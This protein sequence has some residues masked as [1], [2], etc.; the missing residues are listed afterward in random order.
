[1]ALLK[2]GSKEYVVD[3]AFI[4]IYIYIYRFII[5]IRYQYFPLAENLISLIDRHITVAVCSLLK[6]SENSFMHS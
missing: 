2:R 3:E 1:M 4:Y 6:G 5:D